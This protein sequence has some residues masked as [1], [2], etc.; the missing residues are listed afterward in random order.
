MFSIWSSK[1]RLDARVFDVRRLP[2]METRQQGIPVSWSS[3]SLLLCLWLQ[4]SFVSAREF[5]GPVNVQIRT[6]AKE[7]EYSPRGHKFYTDKQRYPTIISWWHQ[8]FTY[9][10]TA[11]VA[12]HISY[13]NNVV[14]S[15]N[16]FVIIAKHQ[17]N[18]F[19]FEPHGL[20]IW[21]YTGAD[22]PF[23]YIQV[24]YVEQFWENIS[25][26]TYCFKHMH[27]NHCTYI[28]HDMQHIDDSHTFLSKRRILHCY[29]IRGKFSDIK[30]NRSNNWSRLYST[31]PL[32]L[33][34][35][36]GEFMYYVDQ[37]GIYHWVTPMIAVAA[38][39][40]HHESIT[41][42]IIEH[43]SWKKINRQRFTLATARSLD[44]LMNKI[45]YYSLNIESLGDEPSVNFID[46]MK[47]EKC[48]CDRIG[49]I[50]R[51]WTQ[52]PILPNTIRGR[53]ITRKSERDTYV[54]PTCEFDNPG[55][56]LGD[57]QV[58]PIE[59]F[60]TSTHHDEIEVNDEKSWYK[61]LLEDFFQMLKDSLS[62][63]LKYVVSSISGYLTSFGWEILAGF[64][65][66][67][68]SVVR[69]YGN[70]PAIFISTICTLFLYY[71]L[72]L[73]SED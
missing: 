72:D 1:A 18:K 25:P 63:F 12:D 22:D 46:K 71:Y 68:L 26:E 28:E 62:S 36:Y 73:A 30:E 6:I 5:A 27:D 2:G 37:Q 3:F 34:T 17:F 59:D 42:M 44:E 14:K 66:P 32:W 24:T 13:G 54:L 43:Y 11:K 70:I 55:I 41:G 31:T 65:I 9:G 19:V 48:K 61:A 47:V 7:I 4:S 45:A 29:G 38:V 35:V 64:I 57:C 50:K 23:C 51:L 60:I 10:P 49:W 15:Y 56:T 33:Q 20:D 16:D 8:A 52:N 69:I 21:L 58:V 67:Y 53:N 39:A 40:Y